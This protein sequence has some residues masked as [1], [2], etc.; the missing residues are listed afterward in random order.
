MSTVIEIHTRFDV[1]TY[2]GPVTDTS[3]S[4]RGGT[5]RAPDIGFVYLKGEMIGRYTY[6][7]YIALLKEHFPTAI[8]EREACPTC[9]R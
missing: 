4:V 6:A 3:L 5:A 2:E 1:P 9:G 8:T 7:E